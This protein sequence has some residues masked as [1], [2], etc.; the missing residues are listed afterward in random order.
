MQTIPWMVPLAIFVLLILVFGIWI[1]ER[2]TRKPIE[3]P[4]EW[5][6]TARPVFTTDERRGY[7]LLR[8]A[9]P[10][11][12]ILSK[13]PLV[14]MCQPVDPNEV[15]YWFELL[16]SSHV[17]FAVCSANGRVLIAIDLDNERS[18]NTNRMV[19]IKR[20]VLNACRVHYLRYP[21]NQMPTAEELQSLAASGGAPV[22][23]TAQQAL[24][25]SSTS[26]RSPLW[27]DSAAFQDSFFAPDSRDDSTS[28]GFTPL[29]SAMQQAHDV[30]GVV[31]ETPTASP[32]S[33]R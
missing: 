4:K 32:P 13:L 17:T 22:M 2:K 28:S 21:S 12:V 3:L 14:R 23:Q 6:L 24:I 29:S 25:A 30:A 1:L 10:H 15:R 19:Q 20:S 5:T 9:L 33:P 26:N 16:N 27:R 18:G 7:R 8:E 31:V 11:H